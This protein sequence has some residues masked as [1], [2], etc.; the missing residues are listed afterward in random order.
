[1]A[2]HCDHTCPVQVAFFKEAFYLSLQDS[3]VKVAKGSANL[4]PYD[5]RDAENVD[6]IIS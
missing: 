3:N 6:G 2:E 5:F 1:M 4:R